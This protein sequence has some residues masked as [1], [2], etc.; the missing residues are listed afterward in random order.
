MVVIDELDVGKTREEVLMDLIYEAVGYR[1]PLDRVKF[2]KP[3]EVDK[4]KD[5][6]LDPNTFIPARVDPTYDDRYSAAGSGFMYR[7]R[8]IINHTNGVDFS[9]VAPPSLPFKMAD[10]LD[11]INERMPYPIQ[12]SDIVNYEY[13]TFAEV[14]EKGIRLQAH[15]ESLLWIDGQT[16]FVNTVYINGKP[17][18]NVKELDG[19]NEWFAP[20]ADPEPTPV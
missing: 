19:F 16:F 17:L 18:I 15:P 11:Q 14:A 13:K 1:V 5:L 20:V 7:R 9:Q 4:R 8:N 6:D 2:G 10:V 3:R 12:L